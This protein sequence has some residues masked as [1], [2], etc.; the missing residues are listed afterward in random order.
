MNNET[1]VNVQY[2]S[3]LKKILMTIG[4]LPSSYLETMSYYEMLVWFTEF[5]RNQVIPTVNN[6]AEAVQELQTLY[7]EL[8]EY[9]NNYFD[10]LDVQEEINNKLE[11]MT[12]DGSLT[13]I[14][15]NYVDPIY[16]EYETTINNAIEGYET[17]VNSTL[18]GFQNQINALESGAPIPVSSTSDMTDTS[19]I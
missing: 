6:N 1:N 19:K 5:L 2:V 16:Q 3:P 9:V 14:I 7:E 13:Q 10:N 11:E 8:R 18:D 17:T 4:E 15:K 12:E